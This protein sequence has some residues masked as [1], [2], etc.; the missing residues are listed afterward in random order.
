VSKGSPEKNE[1]EVQCICG[2]WSYLPLAGAAD[3]HLIFQD[4]CD[5]CG[6]HV[7]VTIAAKEPE[8]ADEHT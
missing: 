4:G 8:D 6:R 2:A 1:I 3:G 7:I 5:A